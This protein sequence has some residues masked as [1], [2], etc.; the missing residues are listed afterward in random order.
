MIRP[1]VEKNIP[2]PPP[3]QPRKRKE[4]RYPWHKMDVG[5]SFFIKARKNQVYIKASSIMA[6]AKG[7]ADRN[8]NGMKFTS[9]IVD[10]GVRIFRIK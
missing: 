2:L 3:R 4:P 8:K 7:W 5:D 10:N 6:C 9:R 1:Q